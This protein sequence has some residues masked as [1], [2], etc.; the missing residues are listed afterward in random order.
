MSNTHLPFDEF[1]ALM[2]ENWPEA[3]SL[4]TT[5]VPRMIRVNEGFQQVIRQVM[6][7]QGLQDADFRL[8]STLRRSGEPYRLSP[9]QLYY[10]MLVSSGGLTKVLH[11]LEAAGLVQRVDNE[12]DGRS[13][14]VELT[15]EGKNVAEESMLAISRKHREMISKVSDEDIEQ[16]DRLLAKV[17][18]SME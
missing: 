14:L 2:R 8:L 12:L 18:Q 13:K 7:A 10:Y 5:A 11:R 9:T 17:L 6:E 16:L 4:M 1:L 3:H 15:P